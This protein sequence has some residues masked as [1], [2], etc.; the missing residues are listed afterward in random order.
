M[1]WL[2]SIFLTMGILIVLFPLAFVSYLNV[3]GFREMRKQASNRV[4]AASPSVCAIDADCPP[5]YVC[6]NGS[7]IPQNG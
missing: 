1:N 3:G 7:C 4:K 2:S 5:G 6:L